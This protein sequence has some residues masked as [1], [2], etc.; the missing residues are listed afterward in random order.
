MGKLQNYP[1][2]GWVHPTSTH[3][4]TLARGHKKPRVHTA[5]PDWLQELFCLYVLFAIFWLGK[6]Y[7]LWVYSCSQIFSSHLD[8]QSL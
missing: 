5:S 4:C 7:E 8:T 6:W 1:S 2:I 3:A